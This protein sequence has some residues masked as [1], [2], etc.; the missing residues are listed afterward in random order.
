MQNAKCRMQ[1]G[2]RGLVRTGR[3]VQSAICNL[4]F[5]FFL[6]VLASLAVPA[7]SAENGKSPPPAP[8]PPSPAPHPSIYANPE[9]K[10]R[11]SLFGLT[12]E[13]YKFVYVLDRSA[14]MGGSGAEGLRILKAELIESLGGLGEVHQFQ[15]VFYNERPVVFNPSG[16]SGRLAFATEENKSRAARFIRS[17]AAE[18]GTRHDDAL[19][20]AIR[21]H[22]DVI[23]FLT[24]GDDPKLSRSELD[25]IGRMAGGITI[26]AVEFGTGKKPGGKSFLEVL[27]GENGGK[28]AY[29]NILDYPS[30]STKAGK[31]DK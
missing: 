15:I 19:K 13:G 20:L 8:R 14:S 18:G 31:P 12:G 10:A 30:G 4:Q 25:Q 2:S 29:V 21:L 3:A 26:Q 5:A 28:Y 9:G 7:A 17:I 24:D 1:D 11:V 6:L 23:F 22:P 27:A 16:M